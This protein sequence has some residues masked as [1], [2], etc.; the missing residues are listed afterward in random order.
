MDEEGMQKTTNGLISI[1]KPIPLD[2]SFLWES[3]DRLYE[4]AYAETNRMKD[5]VAALVPTYH[6]DR[7]HE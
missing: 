5:Y 4:E 1:A 7:E 2:E 6:I 3:L